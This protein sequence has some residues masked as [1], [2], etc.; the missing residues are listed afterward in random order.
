VDNFT[1]TKKQNLCN[2]LISLIRESDD[3]LYYYDTAPLGNTS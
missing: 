2:P 1:D 3:L